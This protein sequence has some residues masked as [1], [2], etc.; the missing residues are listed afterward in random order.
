MNINNKMIIER[1]NSFANKYLMPLM[2]IAF[3]AMNTV[4]DIWI[5]NR[6]ETV[7]NIL[8]VPIIL[9][10]L[11]SFT[12]KPK[13]A[14]ITW[15]RENAFVLV[16]FVI[17][18]ASF[19]V[20]GFDYSV[21]RSIFFEIVFLVC[22]NKTFISVDK[23]GTYIK[24]FMCFEFLIT[25]IGFILYY[26]SKVFGETFYNFLE[27]ITFI[28]QSER[29]ILYGNVNTAGIVA[30]FAVVVAVAVYNSNLFNKKIVALYGAY[31]FIAMLLYGC[32]SADVGILVSFVALLIVV[33]VPKCNRQLLTMVII[34]TMAL[35]VIPIYGA[36]EI[37]GQDN[38]YEL[39]DMEHKLNDLSTGRYMIWKECYMM[40]QEQPLLGYGSL[41]LER[42]ARQTFFS[43]LG[44]DYW[45]YEEAAQI[46]PH[47]GY[48]GI[49]SATGIL[50]LVAFVLVMLDKI[51]KSNLMRTGFWYLIPVYIFAVNCFEST[52][53]L[54]RFVAFFFMLVI[55]S[56]DFLKIDEK[57]CIKGGDK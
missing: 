42:E 52:F 19:A 48:I 37:F 43:D 15:L 57:E 32:R 47:N 27:S 8:G 1:L 54:N 10:F 11:Y 12:Y 56:M 3:L 30:G 40:Q 21:I 23:K 20:T 38:N 46:A 9:I 39:T 29:A 50:G 2:A 51:K 28:A 49:L 35:S 33:I 45:R 34:V 41:R 4:F 5:G 44:S 16:Y 25:F 14:I 53:I 13:E 24:L 31:N 6:V 17:R 26:A 55:L 7:Q 36:V 18:F 22:I